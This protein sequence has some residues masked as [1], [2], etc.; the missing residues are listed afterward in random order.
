LL[1][2]LMAVGYALAT[3]FAV[4]FVIIKTIGFR[5]E[6]EAEFRGSDLSI[7]QINAYP[8]DAVSR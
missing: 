5:L 8:E 7:H 2:S 3:G 6:D 1:G 4:Y